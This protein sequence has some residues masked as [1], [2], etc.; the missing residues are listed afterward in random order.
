M[1]L[2]IECYKNR[3]KIYD[4]SEHPF[5]WAQIQEEIGKIYYLLGKQDEDEK[6]MSE[7]KNYYLSAQAIYQELNAKKAAVETQK[8]L[9]K[10]A[11]YID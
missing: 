8:M 3:Q 9:T 2:A 10:I 11:D 1:N 5:E 7:A 4:Q 6:L